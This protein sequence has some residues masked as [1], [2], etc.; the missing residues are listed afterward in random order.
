MRA[1]VADRMIHPVRREAEASSSREAKVK[2]GLIE[3]LN[4]IIADLEGPGRLG[5]DA[6]AEASAALAAAIQLTPHGLVEVI[7]LLNLSLKCLRGTCP[8]ADPTRRLSQVAAALAEAR[9]FL[10]AGGDPTHKQSIWVAY[11]ELYGTCGDER[12]GSQLARNF[13]T[14]H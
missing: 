13:Y 5:R 7:P 1:A 2:Q 11:R 8:E 3:A 14:E 4:R 10:L 9:Q 6:L 12:Q